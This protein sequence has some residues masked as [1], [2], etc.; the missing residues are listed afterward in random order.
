[1][2]RG[3]VHDS[4]LIPY[5]GKPAFDKFCQEMVAL[6]RSKRHLFEVA[7]SRVR[8]RNSAV[9]SADDVYALTPDERLQK[10]TAAFQ[11]L[12]PPVSSPTTPITSP[13]QKKRRRISSDETS[14]RNPK[15]P[16]KR[17]RKILA[18]TES[19]PAEIR[20]TSSALGSLS[21]ASRRRSST[22]ASDECRAKSENLGAETS[23]PGPAGDVPN[24]FDCGSLA[25]TEPDSNPVLLVPFTS[26]KSDVVSGE[27]VPEICSTE[28]SDA[29]KLIADKENLAAATAGKGLDSLF[30]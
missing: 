1:M 15:P 22:T 7:P 4:H 8:A 27:A 17:R 30:L 20:K 3:W 29:A 25:S 28:K 11:V 24:G 2:E 9:S 12:S 6:H 13:V 16:L 18:A 19:S 14:D 5:D 26:D 21:P 10:L 23:D